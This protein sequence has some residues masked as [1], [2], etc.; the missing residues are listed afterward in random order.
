MSLLNLG[1]LMSNNYERVCN[2]VINR[3]RIFYIGLSESGLLC[4]GTM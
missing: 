3:L 4:K 2:S 1:C